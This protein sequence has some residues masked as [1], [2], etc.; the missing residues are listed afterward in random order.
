MYTQTLTKEIEQLIINTKMNCSVEKFS[1]KVNWYNI[2]MYQKLSEEFIE[3]FSDKLTLN[4]NSWLYTSTKTKLDYIKSKTNYEVIDDSY[5]IVYKGIRSN[6]YSKFNFQYK[7]EV[8]NIYTS[9]CDCNLDN[10]NSFGLSAWTLE[11]A[12]EYC[13]EKVIK[14]KIFIK[15]IGAIVHEGNKIRCSKFTV[16]EEVN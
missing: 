5:I 8:G 2:S 6:N 16:L 12:K 15:D 13:N 7:Y 3:K 1:D 14:V 10:E 9:H 11:K 4:K